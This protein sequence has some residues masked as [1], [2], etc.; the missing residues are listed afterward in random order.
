MCFK[1]W[2]GYSPYTDCSLIIFSES[3]LSVW[4]IGS[5][6]FTIPKISLGIF[7][8]ELCEICKLICKN[9]TH[10]HSWIFMFKNMVCLSYVQLFLCSSYKIGKLCSGNYCFFLLNLVILYL[11]V[12]GF[13]YFTWA[14]FHYT[15]IYM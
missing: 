5:F 15:G 14:L 11:S 4:A 6:N 10:L 7:L 1:I 9:I 12:F 3:F 13:H 8:L 2:W